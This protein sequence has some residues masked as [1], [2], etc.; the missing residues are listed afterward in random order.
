MEPDDLVA[1]VPITAEHMADAAAGSLDAPVPSCPGWDV[2]TAVTH[3]G[4]VH[5]WATD[6][7]QT[8][9][10]EGRR[11]PPEVDAPEGDRVLTWLVEGA[12]TVADVCRAKG[13]E[14]PVWN[15]TR[16]DQV[17]RFWFRRMAHETAMHAWDV[18]N[19]LGAPSGFEPAMASDA[20]DELL[21]VILPARNPQ[22]MSG[23]LHVHCT[24]TDGEWVV[25]LATL[26]VARQHAKADAALRGP[27]SDLLLRLLHRGDGGTVLGE[28]DVLARWQATFRF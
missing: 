13:P 5:R 27:A 7:V 10:S 6:L 24:D 9:A 26:A 16:T 3:L 1:T 14:A 8:N 11:P 12:A 22:G 21:T 23:T 25:D 20:I 2:R 15:W 4:M 28:E 18:R 19:A 17:A